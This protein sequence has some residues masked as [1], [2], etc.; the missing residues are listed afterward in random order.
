MIPQHPGSTAYIVGRGPSLLGL[1]AGDFGPGPVIA[2]NSTIVHLRKLGLSNPVYFMW[3]DGCLPHGL[4][5]N[6]PTEHDCT[7]IRP[8]PGEV[9]VT[10]LAE[11]R[12]CLPDYPLRHVVDVEALGVPWY[13]MSAPVA[14]LVAHA[15]G[16]SDVIM[17]GQDGP[18]TGD[19]HAVDA[20]GTLVDDPHAGYPIA[21]RNA[22]ELAADHGISLRWEMPKVPA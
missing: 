6:N 21:T 15:M 20:D 8:E 9:F 10:S 7:L 16:C 3:K 2:L 1:T 18:L 4:T 17:L 5:D 13:T 11:G 19:W 22:V 14:V 12:Y